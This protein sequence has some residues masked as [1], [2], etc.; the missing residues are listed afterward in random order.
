MCRRVIIN[1]GIKNVIVR[2]T[3]SEYRNISV[4]DEWVLYADVE[5]EMMGYGE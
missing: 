4:Q 1:A 3:K 5:T 2:D